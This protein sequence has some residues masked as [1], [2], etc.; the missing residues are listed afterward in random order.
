MKR[1]IILETAFGVGVLVLGLFLGGSALPA[2]GCCMIALAA[3]LS[4][5]S[6]KHHGLVVTFG[7][8]SLLL[9]LWQ[10]VSALFGV[11]SRSGYE[12]A[13]SSLWVPLVLALVLLA[14]SFL[15]LPLE[16]R[17]DLPHLSRGI[18][19]IVIFSGV[20]MAGIVLTYLLSYLLYATVLS[21][22][23]EQGNGIQDFHYLEGILSLAMIFTSARSVFRAFFG[24]EPLSQ[25]VSHD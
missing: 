20:A 18:H 22:L 10:T 11:V 5:Y 19:R 16:D 13:T 7:I 14:H 6:E 12:D 21:E 1:Y 9:L 24:K 15:T 25:E 17:S 4:A 8:L 2:L 23:M 3:Q